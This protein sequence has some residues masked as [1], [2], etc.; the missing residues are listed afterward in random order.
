MFFCPLKKFD[1][2]QSLSQK[3]LIKKNSFVIQNVGDIIVLVCIYIVIYEIYDDMLYYV[4]SVY[5]REKFYVPID[6]GMKIC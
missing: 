2:K 4:S 3:K 5:L 6:F 1:Q